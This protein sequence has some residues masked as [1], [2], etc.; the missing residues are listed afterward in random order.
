MPQSAISR[1]SPSGSTFACMFAKPEQEHVRCPVCAQ[2]WTEEDQSTWVFLEVT[3]YTSDARPGWT[4]E[5]FCSQAHAADWLAQPLPP[6]EPVTSTPRS[7]RDRLE[8]VS[9]MALFGVPAVLACV[10]LVAIGNW[11]GLYG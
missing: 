2:L 6:F 7:A 1:S 3:R 11:L 10:G 9:L 8:E 5:G 4:H